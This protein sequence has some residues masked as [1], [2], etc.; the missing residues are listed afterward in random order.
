MKGVIIMDKEKMNGRELTEKELEKVSGGGLPYPGECP[1][2]KGNQPCSSSS[3]GQ[4][5]KCDSCPKNDT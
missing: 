5:S 2:I 1:Y 3:K 4:L